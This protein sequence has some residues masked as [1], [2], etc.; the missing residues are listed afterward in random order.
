MRRFHICIYRTVWGTT[1]VRWVLKGISAFLFFLLSSFTS[2]ASCH[3]PLHLRK[4]TAKLH[5][6]QSILSVQ[7]P[8]KDNVNLIVWY[9]MKSKFCNRHWLK[10]LVCVKTKTTTK[11]KHTKKSFAANPLLICEFK[12]FPTSDSF[13]I[14]SSVDCTQ[15]ELVQP[16]MVSTAPVTPT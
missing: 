2:P 13:I 16:V 5:C 15:A 3:L 12:V 10:Q 9:N 14:K 8:G 11:K 4:Y 6:T 7:K 1:V